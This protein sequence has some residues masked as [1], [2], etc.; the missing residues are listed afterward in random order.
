MVSSCRYSASSFGRTPSLRDG[1][2]HVILFGIYAA[3]TLLKVTF[4]VAIGLRGLYLGLARLL[5]VALRP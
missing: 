1:G 2:A 3:R 5:S 4:A